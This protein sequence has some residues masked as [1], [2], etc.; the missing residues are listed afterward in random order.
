MAGTVT[1]QGM[2]G[3]TG[4]SGTSPSAPNGAPGTDGQS[5]TAVTTT[6]DD[7]SNTADADKVEWTLPPNC[8]AMAA[9]WRTESR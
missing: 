8:R 1:V 9:R 6:P 2:A 5:A 4:A 3:M 7:S